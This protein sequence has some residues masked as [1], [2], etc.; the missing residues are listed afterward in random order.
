MTEPGGGLGDLFGCGARIDVGGIVASTGSID[1]SAFMA[2][3]SVLGFRDL[4]GGAVVNDGEISVRDG[5]LAAFVAPVV[6]NSG[7]IRARWGRIALA[8]GRVAFT[9]DLYGDCLVNFAVADPAGGRVGNPGRLMAEGGIVELTAAEAH[10]VVGSVINT[11]GVVSV[12]SVHVDGGTIVLAGADDS[13]LTVAGELSAGG[14]N[15]GRIGIDGG[16]VEI[17]AGAALDASGVGNDGGRIDVWST[18]GL[19]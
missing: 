11:S 6:E 13:I 12:A 4:G 18:P 16:Q 15:G 17:A 10:N 3:A 7:I 9:L 19:V 1:R 14:R 5:G 2:G 8:G